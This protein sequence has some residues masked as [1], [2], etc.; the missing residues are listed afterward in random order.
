MSASDEHR[1]TQQGPNTDLRK[2]MKGTHGCERAAEVHRRSLVKVRSMQR[3][4]SMKM[5]E[6]MATT[7]ELEWQRGE[8]E[9]DWG[10]DLS[11]GYL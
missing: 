9:D 8:E 3:P 1:R 11:C 5:R 10:K 2:G 7:V 4:E 6:S